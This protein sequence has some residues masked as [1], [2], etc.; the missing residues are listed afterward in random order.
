MKK[1]FLALI[2]TGF[3][4]SSFAG[5]YECWR[6]VSDKPQGYVSVSASSNS[7]AVQIAHQK[8]DKLGKKVEY[9]KCK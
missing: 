2:L 4:S 6:Y 1:L 9:I 3:S 7:D 5:S 8:F